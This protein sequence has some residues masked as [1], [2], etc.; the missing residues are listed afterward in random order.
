MQTRSG[1]DEES[2]RW[3]KKAY[4]I[5]PYDLSMAASYGYALVFAGRYAE[6]T[7]LLDRAVE[8]I[9]AHPTW[10]DFGLFLGLYMTG[11]FHRAQA[12]SSALVANDSS[13][14]LAA[15]LI[16]ADRTGD[17]KTAGKLIDEIRQNYP[18]FAANPRLAFT[19]R[20]YPE[21]MTDRLANDL[22][23]TGLVPPR[24]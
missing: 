6:G 23:H 18:R 21:D 14:Y 12:V 1:L 9:S 4:E 5:N 20:N 17:A 15:R 11:D 13:H 7:P 2:L 22:A 24:Q 8:A 16:V 3:M 19:T 10:W